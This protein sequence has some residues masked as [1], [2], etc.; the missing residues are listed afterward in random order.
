MSTPTIGYSDDKKKEYAGRFIGGALSFLIKKFGVPEGLANSVGDEFGGFVA[1]VELT[2]NSAD[3]VEKH[4]GQALDRTW[5][6]MREYIDLPNEFWEPLEEELFQTPDTVE[7]FLI[8]YRDIQAEEDNGE[9]SLSL[10]TQLDSTINDIH[11]N[12][13]MIDVR[14]IPENFSKKL[15]CSL[16]QEIYNDISLLGI[17]QYLVEKLNQGGT[18]PIKEST[19]ISLTTIPAAVD[20]IG[21]DRDITTIKELLGHHPIVSIYADG[22]VG[23]TALA[24]RIINNTKGEIDLGKSKFKHIAWI[25]STADLKNDLSALDI[26]GTEAAE[27]IDERYKAVCAFLET[28]PT[29]L[30]ID[31]MDVP[32][33]AEEINVINTVSGSTKILIT[34]RIKIKNS[35][36]YPLEP[37]DK[38]D[39]ITL[40]YKH[41]LDVTEGPETKARDDK[42]YVEMI[43]DKSSRNALLIE[44]IAK[45]A[46]WEYTSRLDELW[47]K[48][49][50]DVFGTDSEIDLETV[51][52]DSHKY[53]VLSED[54]LKLQGQIR[55]LY[56]MSGLDDTRQELMRFI[57]SFP[58]ETIIFADAFKWAGYKVSDL[59]YLTERGWIEK[60]EEGYLIHTMVRGSVNL[61]NSNFDIEKY[62]NL[63]KKL[64]NTEKYVSLTDSYKII[65]KRILVP[66]CVC[67]LLD[68]KGSKKITT[69]DLFH[70]IALLYHEQSKYEDALKYYKKA[71]D[72]YEEKLGQKHYVTVSTYN[73]LAIL[74]R[75]QGDY[76]DAIEYCKKALIILE[77]KL[78]MENEV[79]AATYNNIASIYQNQGKYEDALSYYKKALLIRE[80]LLGTE[81]VQTAKSY[82]NLS[83][84]YRL[85]G[86]YDEALGYCKKTLEI[87]EKKLGTNH[88]STAN[89]YDV[90]AQLYYAKD[91]YEKALEY[92]GKALIIRKNVFGMN[93]PDIATTYNSIATVYLAQGKYEEA[94]EKYNAALRIRIKVLGIKHPSTA[95]L[96]SNIALVYRS[97][98]KYEEA[99]K[100]N[101][102]ALEIREKALG[103]EHPDTASTYNQIALIY[104]IQGKNEEAIKYN[105]MALEIREKVQGLKHPD[106]ATTYNNIAVVYYEMGKNEE[107][108]EYNKKAL[109]IREKVLGLEHIDTLTTYNNIAL[110]YCSQ[111]EY[112][113]ALKYNKK[114]LE[115]AQK[116]IGIKHPF[117]ATFFSNIASV[118]YEQGK[119]E[120]AIDYFEKALEIRKEII[121]VDHPDTATTYYKLGSVYDD[122]HNHEES[123]NYFQKAYDIFLKTFGSEHA[124]TKNAKKLLDKVN[125]EL[126]Q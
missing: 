66:E 72:I 115:I 59:K 88:P 103:L 113:E 25:K 96:Y 29:F 76:K 44:L 125:Q 11:K 55:N 74:Y 69:A 95:T 10:Y 65:A 43:V 117:T 105:K 32:P 102:I 62:E 73:N 79:T 9:I 104:R 92:C 100:Y 24:L 18:L 83:V 45:M 33:S 8:N 37:M 109:E 2:D 108:L 94:L 64:S 23:K 56:R 3:T 41:Y 114:S 21:R 51:H 57:A 61:Q 123:K 27:S 28:K 101:K 34:T 17:V 16:K 111:G 116:K 19:K 1:G 118:Y 35:L 86:K 97:Q 15:A 46:C 49:E 31:N 12:S 67:R 84:L 89:T 121:G 126:D 99:I 48:L 81:D 42:T 106:T 120:E 50:K 26:P 60:A 90:F 78:D 38:Q 75:D 91:N 119:I 107:A 122:L 53:G 68:K 30:V 80:R 39:A 58:S 7:L 22:G 13:D 5:K 40:F 63:I 20:L 110:V 54:N 14:S 70:N 93:H 71:L 124:K 36:Q 85:L 112:E 47:F 52:A 6:Q 98:G 77:N 4:W 87:R 82:N